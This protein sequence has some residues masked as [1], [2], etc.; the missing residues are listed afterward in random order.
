M[1]KG[2]QQGLPAMYKSPNSLEDIIA[3]SNALVDSKDEYSQFVRF[4]HATRE[5]LQAYYKSEQTAFTALYE[6]DSQGSLVKIIGLLMVERPV[7]PRANHAVDITFAVHPEFRRRGIAKCMILKELD[8]LKDL[9]E[10]EGYDLVNATVI[11]ENLPT[12]MLLQSIGFKMSGYA[13]AKLRFGGKDYQTVQ[14]SLSLKKY[15][16]SAA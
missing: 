3:F 4:Y 1:S 6:K 11:S 5:E 7:D 12:R 2:S 15:S 13:D 16:K 9:S 10:D 8:R 14:Y